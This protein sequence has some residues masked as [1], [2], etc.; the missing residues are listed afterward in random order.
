M[1]NVVVDASNE[2]EEVFVEA[3]SA[4]VNRLASEVVAVIRG[5]VIVGEV[6]LVIAACVEAIPR[7]PGSLQRTLEVDAPGALKML[8]KSSAATQPQCMQQPVALPPTPQYVPD[9]AWNPDL[10]DFE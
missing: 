1:L 4:V 3:M 8:E 9:P 6:L 10:L 2:I 5:V 7:V